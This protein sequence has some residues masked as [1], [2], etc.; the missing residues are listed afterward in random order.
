MAQNLTEEELGPRALGVVEELLRFVL[1]DDLPFIHKDDAVGHLTGKA[2]LVRH[3]QH[4]HAL[5]RETDH[6]VEHFLD[7]FR[8]ERRGR[9]VEQHDAR[10]HAQRTR[11]GDALLLTAGE[12]AGI[13]VGL[14]RNLDAGEEVHRALLGLL[15]RHLA[16]P[17][18]RQGAVLEDGQMWK[19]VEVLEHHANLGTDP[20]DVLD[21]RRQPGAI[22]RDRAFLMF[23]QRVDAAD[24][25][26][27][28]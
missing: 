14:L 27:F 17:D 10:I 19:E 28:A 12:L 6:R 23:F 9:L 21:V 4:G 1:F 15:L 13:F 2:H 11:D 3:A 18:R 16:H 5:L 22:D 26:G 24:Q 7:H 20:V 25:G 8:V